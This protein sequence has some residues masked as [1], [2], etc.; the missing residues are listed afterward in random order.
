MAYLYTIAKNLC[1]DYF[2]RKQA[3][4]LTDDYPVEDFAEQSDIKAAV[5]NALE[6]LDEWQREIIVLRYIGGLSRFWH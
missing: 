1:V 2:R 6:K 3:L 5:R 4:E